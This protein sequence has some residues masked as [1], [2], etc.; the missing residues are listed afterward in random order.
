MGLGLA[1]AA[2]SLYELAVLG[3]TRRGVVKLRK[4]A[5]GA[6]SD[7]EEGSLSDRH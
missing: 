1:A 4:P 3:D 5:A 2:Y 6:E 7:G